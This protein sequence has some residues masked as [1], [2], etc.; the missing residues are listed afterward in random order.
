[1]G[2]GISGNI[3]SRLNALKASNRMSQAEIEE[4]LSSL[5]FDA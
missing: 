5:G 1:M 2:E 4:Y 3:I